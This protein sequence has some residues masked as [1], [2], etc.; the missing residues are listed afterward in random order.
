MPAYWIDPKL[1][2][3]ERAQALRQARAAQALRQARQVRA[4]QRRRVLA[5][6]AYALAV[7]SLAVVGGFV[8]VVLQVL[9]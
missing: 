8:I 6:V 5:D 4:D 2:D 3:V 7:V 9:R 1:N